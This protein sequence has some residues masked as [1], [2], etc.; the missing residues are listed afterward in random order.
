M[1]GM[2][3]HIQ[4]AAE[5]WWVRVGE[6]AEGLATR[7]CETHGS[8]PEW[9]VVLIEVSG[10]KIHTE[11]WATND[12]PSTIARPGVQIQAIAYGELNNAVGDLS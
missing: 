2:N 4:K 1:S 9:V 10:P 6:E 8:W 5:D 12:H 11:L 7:W 3:E